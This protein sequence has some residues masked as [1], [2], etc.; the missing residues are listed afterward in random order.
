VEHLVVCGG[1]GRAKLAE[2]AVIDAILD[3]AADECLRAVRITL[4]AEA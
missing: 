2:W 3:L 4:A 1:E